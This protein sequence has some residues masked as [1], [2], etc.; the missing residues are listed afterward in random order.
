[1]TTYLHITKKV[2]MPGAIRIF[3]HASSKC[4]SIQTD[5]PLP[6]LLD[7][8][9]DIQIA[10]CCHDSEISEGRSGPRQGDSEWIR[11]LGGKNLL[12]NGHLKERKR[13]DGR[14]EMGLRRICDR[15]SFRMCTMCR[16]SSGVKHST[17]ATVVL[18]YFKIYLFLIVGGVKLGPL[19]TA[20]TNR[21]TVPNPGWL[22]WWRNCWNDDWQG[23]PKY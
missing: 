21:P 22:W 17:S 1:M 9:R 7:G 19:G 16:L 10:L 5:L 6:Y 15:N 23:K 4:S 13:D 20:T 12:E 11:N 2:K 14:R 18:F 8:L 3:P